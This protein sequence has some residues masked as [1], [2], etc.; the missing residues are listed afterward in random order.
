[1]KLKINY[2]TEKS[3]RMQNNK[4]VRR[5]RMKDGNCA[6]GAAPFINNDDD[7]QQMFYLHF[8]TLLGLCKR[9]YK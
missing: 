5:M 6:Q 7:L 3:N 9:L 8:S 1:M 4:F 2:T